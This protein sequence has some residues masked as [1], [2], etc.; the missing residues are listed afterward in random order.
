MYSIKPNN[1]PERPRF[2][3]ILL[4][5]DDLT[6]EIIEEFKNK[7]DAVKKLKELNKNTLIENK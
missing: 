4:N 2:Y 5:N 7:I 6:Y 3:L 1:D